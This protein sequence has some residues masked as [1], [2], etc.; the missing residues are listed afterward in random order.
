MGNWVWTL[1]IKDD[2]QAEI[3]VRELAHR[4]AAKLRGAPPYVTGVREW[5]D[6]FSE[7]TEDWTSDDFDAVWDRLYDWADLQRVWIKTF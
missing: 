6:A 5:I 1:D 3:P 2:W 4:V 7:A